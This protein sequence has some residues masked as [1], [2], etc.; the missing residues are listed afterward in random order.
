MRNNPRR[1][2]TTQSV[3][4]TV[5]PTIAPADNPPWPEEGELDVPEGVWDD[6]RGEDDG[7]HEEATA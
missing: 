4:P 6:G 1:Q 5:I 3:A 7:G 2:T